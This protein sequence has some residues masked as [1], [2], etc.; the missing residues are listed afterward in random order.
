[1]GVLSGAWTAAESDIIGNHWDDK[2][3][4]N[5]YGVYDTITF[6]LAKTLAP[7]QANGTPVPPL[8][9][10]LPPKQ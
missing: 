8:V 6:I 2:D 1:L 7:Y 10:G 9:C 3:N 5:S 4:D